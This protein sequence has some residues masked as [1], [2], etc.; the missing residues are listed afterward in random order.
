MNQLFK[1]MSFSFLYTQTQP[2][3]YVSL[4][5]PNQNF[6]TKSGCMGT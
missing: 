1:L 4:E 6:G 3:D 2:I 5:N